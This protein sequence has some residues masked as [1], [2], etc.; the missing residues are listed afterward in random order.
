MLTG[1]MNTVVFATHAA[2]KSKEKMAA[3]SNIDW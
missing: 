3:T 1:I 2:F